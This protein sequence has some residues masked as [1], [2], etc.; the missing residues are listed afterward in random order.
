[1]CFASGCQPPWLF[2]PRAA[3]GL[4]NYGTEPLYRGK[5]SWLVSCITTR[6]ILIV[7]QPSMLSSPF[8]LFLTL[9]VPSLVLA[10]AD[11]LP[12]VPGARIDR[13]FSVT[14]NA[15]LVHYASSN[16]TDSKITHALFVVHGLQ[17]DAWN[18]FKAA[19]ASVT[20]AAS[21]GLVQASQVHIAAPVFFNG[22]DRGAFPVDADGNPTTNQLVWQGL[23]YSSLVFATH[24]LT[25]I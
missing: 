22:N 15:L 4:P 8:K 11:P 25:M 10:Q 17:R 6:L 20:A 9:M 23:L 1:M 3:V 18:A 16:V 13:S 19:Q 7:Y 12:E 24:A 21:A 2:Q 5:C 14:S